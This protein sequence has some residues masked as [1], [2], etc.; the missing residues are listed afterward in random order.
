MDISCFDSFRTERK[1]DYSEHKVQL[2]PP[3]DE[4]QSTCSYE[5][6]GEN[7]SSEVW[8]YYDN[9]LPFTLWQNITVN[10]ITTYH[11][12]CHDNIFFLKMTRYIML[13]PHICRLEAS[14]T[15]QLSTYD[16]TTCYLLQHM[17]RLVTSTT[18]IYIWCYY[19]LFIT[20]HVSPGHVHNKTTI[21]IWCYYLLFITTHVSPNHVHNN[22]YLH[23]MLLLII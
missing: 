16:V 18:T 11:R 14:T 17:C 1:Y 9:I 15:K 6:I 5:T 23:M 4:I 2:L 10:T 22:N 19:L 8:Y 21:Y 3:P 20:T 12:L 13:I 7:L